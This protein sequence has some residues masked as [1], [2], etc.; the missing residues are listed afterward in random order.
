MGYKELIEA[1]REEGEKKVKEIW[2]EAEAGAEKIMKETESKID[3]LKREYER[4]FS[5]EAEKKRTSM[6]SEA[7]KEASR[8]R[9]DAEEYLSKRL[10]K[11]ALEMLQSL[12]KENYREVFNSLLREIPNSDWVTVR[13]N[14]EDVVLAQ[15]LLPGA[16]VISDD[17][18][19]G[20]FVIFNSDGNIITNTFEKRLERLWPEILPE[21]LKTIREMYESPDR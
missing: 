19:I 5:L 16:K 2:R 18:I 14:P 13:V 12:R 7:A 10:F 15:S 9:L 6:L 20:G 4:R 11:V 8:M 1:L 3:E 17:S 21:I